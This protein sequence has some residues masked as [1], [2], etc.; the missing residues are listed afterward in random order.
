ML[1]LPT[2]YSLLLRIFNVTSIFDVPLSYLFK[3]TQFA[4]S[5]PKTPGKTDVKFT[6]LSLSCIIRNSFLKFRLDIWLS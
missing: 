5:Q 2:S 6:A 1:H 3:G 4:A